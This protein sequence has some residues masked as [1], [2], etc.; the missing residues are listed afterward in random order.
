MS[1]VQSEEQS[2]ASS[3]S[4]RSQK[5]PTFDLAFLHSESLE[6]A[7]TVTELT[8][9][10]TP[11]SSPVCSPGFLKEPSLC[12][13]YFVY[14]QENETFIL[15][16][17][18]EAS[19]FMEN[20]SQ[21]KDFSLWDL[22]Q[23]RDFP[24]KP[25]SSSFKDAMD[26]NSSVLK[27]ML[28]ALQQE[29]SMD[30]QSLDSLQRSLSPF[31][32]EKDLH[33]HLH[34]DGTGAGFTMQSWGL[35]SQ[36]PV[37]IP[38]KVTS[39]EDKTEIEMDEIKLSISKDLRTLI[40]EKCLSTTGTKSLLKEIQGDIQGAKKALQEKQQT[41]K[42]DL[43]QK[44]QQHEDF[45]TRE[46]QELASLEQTRQKH[47]ETFEK[48]IQTLFEKDMQV[49]LFG[50]SQD[51]LEKK[52]KGL[53]KKKKAWDQNPLSPFYHAFVTRIVPHTQKLGDLV[54]K[55]IED[56]QGLSLPEARQQLLQFVQENYPS[57]PSLT[58]AKIQVFLKENINQKKSKKGQKFYQDS[59]AEKFK[60]L[61]KQSLG[62]EQAALDHYVYQAKRDM[63]ESL[64]LDAMLLKSL[65]QGDGDCQKK[66]KGAG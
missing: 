7:H 40:K 50:A 28:F 5:T 47:I 13:R 37:S 48:D 3:L 17:P 15:V 63:K 9:F 44:K 6:N 49:T 14:C 39:K 52:V 59:T 1:L 53:E 23:S 34:I 4:L 57:S 43:Q 42:R 65:E 2:F 35:S 18:D 56:I 16:H 12:L 8:E 45:L 30:T 38:V 27:C 64:S 36:N 58:S 22:H 60:S 61:L 33:P 20:E 19:L 29:K 54:D 10:F 11:D 25:I 24:W 66:S 51:I 32:E 62:E 46:R 26:K 41:G 55:K 31:Y 21:L